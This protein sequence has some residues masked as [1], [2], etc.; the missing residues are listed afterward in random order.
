M[1]VP[2]V[3]SLTY[4]ARR[5]Y[6]ASQETIADW[7]ATAI[8]TAGSFDLATDGILMCGKAVRG[9][10]LLWTTTD[11]WTMT[12]IGGDLLY[13]FARVGNNCGIVGQHAA[14]VLD[15]GAFWMGINK[16]L[17]YDGYVRTLV[18]DVNDYVF[19]ALNTAQFSKVWCLANPQFGEVTWF[20]PTGSNTE[21]D[22]YVTYNYQEAHWSFGTMARS[23]GVT[24]QPAGLFLG[25]VMI[26]ASGHIYD[27][28][29]GQSRTGQTPFLESGPM[30]IGDGDTVMRLQRIVPDDHSL[31]DVAAYLYTAMAPDGAETL[32]GPYTL[33]SQTS[34]RVTAR[35]VRLRLV[36]TVADAWRVGVI[37]L[38]AIAGGRR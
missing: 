11:L 2:T 14:I 6:W 20:Y 4:S 1:P 8:N 26:D 27:H 7:I 19:G 28:E 12:Y 36:E 25:P 16:F 18:C 17:S 21:C 3:N 31:G 10:T 32:N 34:V 9:Q 5:L 30:E 23:C 29:T 38:G 35:Q 33:A 15:A 24:I 22:S 37:R 13:S